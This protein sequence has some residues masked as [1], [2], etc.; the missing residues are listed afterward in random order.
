MKEATIIIPIFPLR[1]VVFPGEKLNLHIF[2]KRYK[3]LINECLMGDQLFGISPFINNKIEEIGTAVKVDI[4]D[5]VYTRGEMDIKTIGLKRFKINRIIPAQNTDHYTTAEINWMPIEMNQSLSLHK[6]LY[7]LSKKLHELLDSDI[8][9]LGSFSDFEI[10]KIIHLLG[11][12]IEQEYK[13]LKQKDQLSIQQFLVDHLKNILPIV[14]ETESIKRKIQS[15][16]H[17]KN[18]IPP[19]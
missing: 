1:L 5:R 11:L 8:D 4:V 19:Y 18:I 9:K 6:E 14:E 13:L 16:G 2:E 7:S 15:N 17:F 12:D 3:K 10:Y